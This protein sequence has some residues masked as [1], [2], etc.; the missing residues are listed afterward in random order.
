[1]ADREERSTELALE[2]MEARDEAEAP[3]DMERDRSAAV[4]RDATARGD[5]RDGPAEDGRGAVIGDGVLALGEEE[6]KADAAADFEGDEAAPGEAA[7][8][9]SES[10]RLN[11]SH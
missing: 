2:V 8:R 6:E 9:R 1:M 7:T 5:V 4:G 3:A 10:T 11:S